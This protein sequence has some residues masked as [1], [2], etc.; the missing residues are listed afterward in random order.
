MKILRDVKKLFIY[1]DTTRL[2]IKDLELRHMELVKR[3]QILEERLYENTNN[4]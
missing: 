1:H 2:L 3:I 4:R